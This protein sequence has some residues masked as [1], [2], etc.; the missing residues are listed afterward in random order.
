M[1]RAASEEIPNSGPDVAVREVARGG[2]LN[3]VGNAV[4]GIG[5]FLLL[6][7]VTTQLGSDGAGV[8][9]VAIALFNIVSK[10]CE[11]GAATGL[12]RTISRDRALGKQHELRANTR[13]AV[14]TSFAASMF[15]AL[16]VY[17]TAPELAGL[18]ARGND[19]GTVTDVLRA[20]SPC[21]AFASVYS[22]LIYGSRGFSTMVPQVCIEKIGR[23]LA[24]PIV[25]LAVFVAGGGVVAGAVA[26]AAVQ[27]LWVV[28]A[29]FAYLRLLQ[30]VER[31]TDAVPARVTAALVRAFMSYSLPR[32][33]GQVFQVAVLWMDT[34]IISAI[35]G[36][37]AAGIYAAGTR[38]LLI[39]IF[40]A[41]AIMQVL[42]PRI[43]ALLSLHKREEAAR[44]Y[45][46]GT[47][48]QTTMTWSVYLVVLFF[49]V[50][51]LRVFGPEYVAA[52]PAL[53]WLAL[54]MLA[55][56]LFG[57]SDTIIL[58]SGRARLS[59][60]NAF[61][62]VTVNLAGNFLLVPHFGITAAGATWAVTLVVAA[63]L[64]A[65]QARRDLRIHAWSPALRAAIVCSTLGV[66][67]PVLL[68]W[69]ALG[70]SPAGLIVGLSVGAAGLSVALRRFGADVHLE[71]LMRSFLPPGRRRVRADLV[72][73]AGT[74][75]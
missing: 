27:V 16:L 4:Y 8:F 10:V 49:S 37:T 36:T 25:V 52:S 61:V 41:E 75:G 17:A 40:T 3:L 74:V 11:C 47:A 14:S 23:A 71:T 64:P 1:Q 19:V 24:Q 51:L 33:L 57:P 60:F 65:Y 63:A 38:Y 69:L 62:A 45:S 26:W 22:V 12:I 46:I 42:G 18:F 7:V 34:L 48:W 50:P 6:G 53:V 59:L 67:V 44:L 35:L 9:L 39:G 31:E 5:N 30:R 32:A 28:P 15:A 55:A 73:P 13:I 29:A 20:M 58:M 2:A 54:A 68:A 43:S 70:P 72:G 21:I 66:G 56:A